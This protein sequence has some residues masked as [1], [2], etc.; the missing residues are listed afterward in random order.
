MTADR[1]NQF[2][3][4]FTI[5]DSRFTIHYMT[6]LAGWQ[7]FYVIVGSSAGALIGLQF[8]VLTL[9][10]QRPAA[11]AAR[12]A[13]ASAAFATPSV[14]HFAVV[15]LLSAMASAPWHGIGIVAILWGIVGVS[16]IVY[17]AITARRLRTQSAYRPVFEDW[18]FHC[19]LP[20]IAYAMLVVA[21]LAAYTRP[22]AFIVGASTLLFLFVRNPQRL[23]W[24]HVSRLHP[25][26]QI[27]RLELK[28]KDC[29]TR[30][31]S[32]SVGHDYD[33]LKRIGHLLTRS[34]KLECSARLRQA[35]AHRTFGSRSLESSVGSYLCSDSATEK[36]SP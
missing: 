19:L 7:N 17:G 27:G 9:I 6:P 12:A 1:Q 21:A 35:E 28:S 3:S 30:S 25:P 33:K 23:G 5:N 34:L 8:V 16:G 14:V 32:L 22:G 2:D 15:L 26:H 13:E 10:A 24:N 31:L 36:V 11:P 20:L 18:L 29:L 4:R